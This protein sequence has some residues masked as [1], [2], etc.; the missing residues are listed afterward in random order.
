MSP[1]GP[2]QLQPER[3]REIAKGRWFLSDSVNST[4]AR[5]GKGKS[6]GIG[7]R[8]SKLTENWTKCL[9]DGGMSKSSTDN[10]PAV[11]EIG[12]PNGETEILVTMDS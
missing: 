2:P 12:A 1:A 8:G 11:L 5:K 4:C 10:T 9:T 6:W 7:V 3:Q